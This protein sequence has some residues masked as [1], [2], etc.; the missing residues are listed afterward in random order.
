MAEKTNGKLPYPEG[1]TS[2]PLFFANGHVESLIALF[3]CPSI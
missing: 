1:S 2:S 3:C